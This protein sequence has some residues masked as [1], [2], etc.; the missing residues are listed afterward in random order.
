VVRP[1]DVAYV[2]NDSGKTVD[3]IRPLLQESQG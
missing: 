1:G 3:V 2:E